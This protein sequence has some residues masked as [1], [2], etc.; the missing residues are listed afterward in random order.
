MLTAATE[1]FVHSFLTLFLLCVPIFSSGWYAL[2]TQSSSSSSN[3]V[4]RLISPTAKS[5][6]SKCLRF[7]Y[8]MFGKKVDYL[9]VYVNSSYNASLG[10]PVWQMRGSQ[11]N[12]WNEAVVTIQQ[13][14]SFALV[15][16]ATRGSSF[17]GHIAIDDVTFTD[18]QCPTKGNPTFK[19]GFTYIYTANI[20]LICLVGSCTFEQDKCGFQDDKADFTWTR[21]R[22]GT[23]TPGTGPIADHTL[24]SRSGY[25]MYTEVNNQRN[26][27]KARIMK[28]YAKTTPNGRCLQFYYMMYGR[29]LGT[30]NVYQKVGSSLGKAIFTK[31]GDAGLSRTWLKGRATLN[32]TVD[33]MVSFIIGNMNA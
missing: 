4:A 11:G 2:I 1:S 25:Y 10:Y 3:D 29:D 7:W 24:G 21:K 26:G 17:A 27:N 15:F 18:G 12:Q 8:H 31:S 5:A 6:G 16:E 23:A 28:T 13:S 32:S 9:R 22:G 20:L 14:S 30:L 33:F 19:S